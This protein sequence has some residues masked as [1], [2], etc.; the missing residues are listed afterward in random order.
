MSTASIINWSENIP[1]DVSPFKAAYNLFRNSLHYEGPITWEE[2]V[3]CSQDTKS[4]WLYCQFYDQITLAWYKAKC[5]YGE[6]EEGVETVL[7]YLEKNVKLIESK[8]NKFTSAYIYRVAY[9]CLYCIC[10]DRK[11]DQDRY[12]LE[13]SNI[14]STSDGD[15]V[16]LFD[17]VTSNVE[18]IM[19]DQAKDEFWKIIDGLDEK[20]QKFIERILKNGQLP[21]HVGTENQKLLASLRVQLL[22][23]LS[24][25][26]R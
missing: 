25:F 21:D 10:H 11:I 22:P 17:T 7:Q 19:Y 3:A 23:Y 6:D 8:K 15:E 4:A 1:T 16:D 2:W 14:V 5:L 20:G 12:A 9:N 26:C 18:D 13:M 24:V